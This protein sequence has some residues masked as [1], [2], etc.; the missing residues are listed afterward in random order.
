MKYTELVR[1]LD[2]F[3]G[4]LT[5][6]EGGERIEITD[7]RAI[8]KFIQA[9]QTVMKHDEG[10][11]LV[12]GATDALASRRVGDFVDSSRRLCMVLR[13]NLDNE[14]GVN[15]AEPEIYVNLSRLEKKYT[16][17]VT[18]SPWPSLPESV[19]RGPAA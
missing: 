13:S 17:K 12:I 5:K 9:H 15:R 2:V 3:E 7:V 14:D 16:R 6:L 11:A 19:R 8:L 1:G 10:R 4:M 18:I